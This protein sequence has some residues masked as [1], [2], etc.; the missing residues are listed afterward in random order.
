M[1]SVLKCDKCGGVVSEELLNLGGF[2]PCR[3]CN[4]GLRISVF[5]AYFRP[6]ESGSTGEK[7]LTDGEASCFFHPKKKAAVTCDS[8]G[9]FICSLCDI[10]LGDD[11]LCSTCVET[12]RK[13]GKIQTMDNKRQRHDKVAFAVAVLPVLLV[14]FF[15]VTPITAPIALYLCV[16]YRKAPTSIVKPTRWRIR[17]AAAFATLQILAWIAFGIAWAAEWEGL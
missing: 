11:H 15:W 2:V 10:Q 16:R 12:G 14:F 13:K 5:P 6:P 8:C 17:V 3:F 7:V 9:R 1:E 4:T